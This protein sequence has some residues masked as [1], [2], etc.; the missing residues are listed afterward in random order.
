MENIY[1]AVPDPNI[2]FWIAVSVADAA[3][4]NPKGAKTI[5]ANNLSTFR[6][7]S[8][9]VFSNGPRSLTLNPPKCTILDSWVFENFILA[10]EPFAKVLPILETCVL[11]NNDLRGKL[12]SSLN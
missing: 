4:V 10:D 11:V 5:L 1:V 8:N 12:I 3:A 2:F 9:P 7:K 6:I